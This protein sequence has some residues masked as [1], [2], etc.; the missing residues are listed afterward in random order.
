MTVK[1]FEEEAVQRHLT[2]AEVSA[3]GVTPI[4]LVEGRPGIIFIPKL[5]TLQRSAG[6]GTALDLTGETIGITVGESNIGLAAIA[7]AGFTDLDEAAFRILSGS[8]ISDPG[9]SGDDANPGEPM[10]IL[11]TVPVGD[12][13]FE[14][15]VQVL[16]HVVPITPL[17]E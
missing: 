14:L 4:T 5:V 17:T 1:V 13:E 11:S 3:L 6:A 2:A 8:N 16:Y 7:H 12:V 9:P 10:R 15:D